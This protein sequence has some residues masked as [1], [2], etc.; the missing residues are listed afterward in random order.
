M[1]AKS[2]IIA[3]IMACHV[4]KAVGG[5]SDTPIDTTIFMPRSAFTIAG[6]P[7]Y[8]PTGGTPRWETDV[9][10]VPTIALGS[11][12]AALAIGLHINQA[13]AW[14]KDDRGPF[15]FEE[16]WPYAL[17]VD[18]LGHIFAGHFMSTFIGDLLMDCGFKEETATIMGG[19]L[20]LAYQT[21]VEVEDGFAT[22]WGFSPSDG[23]ANAVGAGFYVAQYYV[24]YLQNFTWRWSYVP[25]RFTGDNELN[26]RPTTFIDDYTSTTFWLA[27]DVERMLPRDV[28]ASWPDWMML[29]VGYGIRDYDHIPQGA[30]EPLEPTRRFMVGLDYNWAR[31]IPDSDI[32]VVNYIRQLLNHMK[33]PGPTVEFS[34]TGTRF[35]LLY[36]FR[37]GIGGIRF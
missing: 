18:K 21:Y 20:G 24:P 28:A 25:S 3:I 27:M 11:A 31:I 29:S 8:T 9:Q 35:H 10:T 34:H 6:D 33:L 5:V 26:A 16:D 30:T 23:V 13:N 37:I 1:P 19:A 15:N 32:G 14:W 17:Q 22:K 12:Y 7:R 2:V 36:P 4:A